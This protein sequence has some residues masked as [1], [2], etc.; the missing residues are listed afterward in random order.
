MLA[1]PS[2]R[3]RVIAVDGGWLACRK[4][5]LRPDLLLGDFD[6]LPQKFHHKAMTSARAV[7]RFPI[8]KDESDLSLA[9]K[10]A[11]QSQDPSGSE[12]IFL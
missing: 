2:K 8:D 10:Y 11:I 12:M 9:L 5:G 7:L 6:S 4:L 3:Y 1:L